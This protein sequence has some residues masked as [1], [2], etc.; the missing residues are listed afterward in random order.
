MPTK[1]K[2]V[3]NLKPGDVIHVTDAVQLPAKTHRVTVRR[4]QEGPRGWF[5]G[6]RMW[7]AYFEPQLMHGSWTYITGH[8]KDRVEVYN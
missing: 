2:L 1:T 3:R 4:V 6:K 7:R 5:S 8:S